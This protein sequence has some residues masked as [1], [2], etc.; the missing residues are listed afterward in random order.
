MALVGGGGAGNTAGGNPS[1]TGSGLNYIGDHAYGFSGETT[2]AASG[3]AAT[4]CLKFT[5]GSSYIVAKINWLT[6]YQG[7]NDTYID[8]LIDGQSVFK[9]VYDTDPHVVNDQP[10]EILI[11]S[12]SDFEFKW[13]TTGVT[14][15][16]TVVLVGRVYA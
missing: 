13:G 8:V 11:P 6:D 4:T 15:S 12:Y 10:L 14:K 7:G 5:T 1:G 16:M 9:G 2:D 3:S